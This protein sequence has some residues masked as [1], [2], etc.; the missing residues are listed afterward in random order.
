MTSLEQS[1]H[2]CDMSQGIFEAKA[3]LFER[4]GLGLE[5]E[6]LSNSFQQLDK[7]KVAFV[8]KT[9]IPL[10]NSRVPHLLPIPA[11]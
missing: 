6:M 11:G 9:G 2:M 7:V 5:D 10:A 1:H 4:R 3:K 8:K